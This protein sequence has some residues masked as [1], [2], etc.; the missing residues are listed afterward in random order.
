MT[1]IYHI[2]YLKYKNK[3]LQLKNIIGGA[4]SDVLLK[5][6]T[7]V[8]T[9]KYI[10]MNPIQESKI[11]NFLDKYSGYNHTHRIVNFLE[12]N[13]RNEIKINFTDINI[14]FN[15]TN[16]LNNYI[17]ILNKDYLMRNVDLGDGLYYAEEYTNIY[18][19]IFEEYEF[20]NI[21]SDN[22]NGFTNFIYWDKYKVNLKKKSASEPIFRKINFRLND[23]IKPTD[24]LLSIIQGPTLCDCG[25]AIQICIYLYLLNLLNIE[26][27]NNLFDKILTPFMITQVLYSNIDYD[28]E[29]LDKSIPL[30]N[31]LYFLFDKIEDFT[32][33]Q[34]NDI[35]HIEGIETY[36]YKH[37]RGSF[38]GYNMIYNNHKFGGFNP[39]NSKWMTYDEV[40]ILLRESYNKDISPDTLIAEKISEYNVTKLDRDDPINIE[41]QY[42]MLYK[43]HKIKKEDDKNSGIKFG[44]RFNHEKLQNFIATYKKC[45][46]NIDLIDLPPPIKNIH[47][48]KTI[49][50]FPKESINN[51]F[52]NFIITKKNEDLFNIVKKFTHCIITKSEPFFL[53]LC[54]NPGIGKTHL[55]ISVAKLVS[56]YKKVLYMNQNFKGDVGDIKPSINKSDLIIIDDINNPSDLRAYLPYLFEYIWTKEKALLLTSNVRLDNISKYIY[57]LIN[58]DHK[59]SY[60]FIKKEYFDLE[61][62][63]IPWTTLNLFTPKLNNIQKI[64]LLVKS[65][66]ESGIFIIDKDADIQRLEQYKTIYETIFYKL[67]ENSK[68]T[69]KI[70][71]IK[72]IMKLPLTQLL[73]YDVLI[74]YINLKDVDYIY[75]FYNLLSYAHDRHI[76]LIIVINDFNTFI[77]AINSFIEKENFYYIPKHLRYKERARI[78]FPYLYDMIETQQEIT[79]QEI[80]RQEIT[81]QEITRQE[82]TRQEIQER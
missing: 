1:S 79:R 16:K 17:N 21:F 34:D 5:I 8:S 10:Q 49:N 82:I 7:S 78:I 54:G 55:T 42:H 46:Y 63:R 38:G 24:G 48:I 12:I 19:T 71:C 72:Q 30:G 29:Q 23:L 14:D 3:Y 35:I 69:I 2:K 68:K 50:D 26:L 6:D 31:P 33:L 39:S 51:T 61:S 52:E 36:K 28:S 22:I 62:Y 45:W 27:F 11:D 57:K 58:Y 15:E 18:K 56:K 70:F 47:E 13:T 74:L 32:K 25:N 4:D 60:N 65:M 44:I 59:Y 9:K 76:K 41:Y 40:I 53:A 67:P 75:L 73:D 77:L 64:E 80:T 81:R 66:G 20:N 37:L 43:N